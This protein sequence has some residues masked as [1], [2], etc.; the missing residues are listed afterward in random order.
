MEKEYKIKQ[1]GFGHLFFALIL[2]V[3]P[4]L[5]AFTFIPALLI[6]TI[7]A[8]VIGLFWLIGLKVVQ[9]NKTLVLTFF[10]KYRGSIMQNGFFWINPF[11]STRNISLRVRN[12]E[13]D[14][15]KVND[16]DGNP[17]LIS[18]VVVWK[19]VDTYK[20]AFDIETNE[21]V[22]SATGIKKVNAEEAYRNFVKIQA[23]AALRKIAHSYPYDMSDEDSNKLSLRAGGDEI[24]K[25]LQDEIKERLSLVGIEILEARISNLSFAP[26]IA[27][28]M[29][30]RQQAQAVIAARTKIVEG[31]VSMVEMALTRI[32]S[33]DIV[34]LPEEGK[35]KIVSN[36]MMV[37]CADQGVTPVVN[38]GMD[39]SSN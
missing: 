25:D 17:I 31:A 34:K 19:I 36:L 2:I 16:L 33:Q 37:L 15:I 3:S 26:E 35:A 18:A 38:A 9:P 12:L 8:A 10:G 4:V 27:A 22:D 1:N 39:P 13:S 32:D 7:V 6:V 20:A 14:V 24:N 29:L 23:E 30:Q 21:Q 28:V 5:N 11:Y